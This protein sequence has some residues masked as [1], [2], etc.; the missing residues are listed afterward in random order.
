MWI[1]IA[2]IRLKLDFLLIRYRMLITIL[3]YMMFMSCRLLI[4]S[5]RCLMMRRLNSERLWIICGLH[6]SFVNNGLNIDNTSRLEMKCRSAT[7]TLIFY[8]ISIFFS[9]NFIFIFINGFTC[10]SLSIIRYMFIMVKFDNIEQPD[11]FAP[12]SRIPP[13]FQISPDTFDVKQSFKFRLAVGMKWNDPQ[14][15]AANTHLCR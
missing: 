10:S 3:N 4:R 12:S 15:P 2:L 6:L 13:R 5:R 1:V 8:F 7:A 9:I 11:A 14:M